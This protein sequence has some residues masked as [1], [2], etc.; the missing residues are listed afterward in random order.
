LEDRTSRK[1]KTFIWTAVALAVS[2]ITAVRVVRTWRSPTNPILLT[3]AVLRQDPDPKK[4]TP[5]PNTKVT[6]LGGLSSAE[7]TSDAS[8]LFKLTVRPSLVPG[9]LITMTFEHAEYKPLEITESGRDL[10]Y[11]IRMEP[12][13]R[14]AVPVQDHASSPAKPAQ[15]SNVRVRYSFKNQTKVNVGSVARQFEVA[16]TGDVPCKGRRP[17]S[18]DGK[19]KASIGSLS[20][21]AQEGNV[22]QNVRASC[23]A[24]PCPF[25]RIEPDNLSRPAR[26]IQITALIW[27]DTASFL[28]EA[29]VTR[30]L[31]TDTVRHSFPFITDQTMTFALPATAEGL[32]VVADLNGEEIVFPLGP[33]LAL[34]WATCSV[35][36]PPGGNKIYRCEVK[37]GYQVQP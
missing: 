3:G 29:E 30:T 16:N 35:E 10:L 28:V 5:I 7:T 23:I 13:V 31:A 8:G 4:Q 18:P 24:G 32:S 11:V 20:L 22:F 9:R 34:S 33:K 2:G 15:I 21:D 26:N 14:H 19:W 12:L 17:C 6:A 25:T 36:V 37:H 1:Q 27:S